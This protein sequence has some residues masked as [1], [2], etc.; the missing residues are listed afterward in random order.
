MLCDQPRAKRHDKAENA[1]LPGYVHSRDK[2][3]KRQQRQKRQ[4]GRGR[5]KHSLNVRRKHYVH[6]DQESQPVE[7]LRPDHP[8]SSFGV[9]SVQ[10]SLGYADKSRRH[11]KKLPIAGER[12]V[13][14]AGVGRAQKCECQHGDVRQLPRPEPCCARLGQETDLIICHFRF[15]HRYLSSNNWDKERASGN[16]GPGSCL[17]QYRR[18]RMGD[19]PCRLR[20]GF[21]V[22]LM[23]AS[24]RDSQ[25]G[26]RKREGF[27]RWLRSIRPKPQW[28]PVK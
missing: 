12:L 5:G 21:G 4:P 24:S 22:I 13:Q 17:I 26:N 2:S 19:S 10:P 3:A 7:G 18:R 20:L 16:G 15:A 25:T 9:V 1:N 28:P 27:S 6:R 11:G 23:G 14:N 8:K